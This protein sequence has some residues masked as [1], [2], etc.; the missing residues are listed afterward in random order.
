MFVMREVLFERLQSVQILTISLL[1]L[2]H[3][4]TYVAIMVQYLNVRLRKLGTIII[5]TVQVSISYSMIVRSQAHCPTG[6]FA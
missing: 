1:G 3:A 4:Y 2:E 5:R 6:N